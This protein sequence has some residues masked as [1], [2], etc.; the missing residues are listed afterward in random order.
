MAGIIVPA[1]ERV[2]LTKPGIKKTSDL[3]RAVSA[4]QTARGGA[5]LA[6]D[7]R[8]DRAIL[9]AVANAKSAGVPLLI[10]GSFYLVT[11]AKSLLA[12]S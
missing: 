1:F 8:F 7:E 9:A 10:T 5:E 12:P 3:D 6:V 4:F 2:T 11:E